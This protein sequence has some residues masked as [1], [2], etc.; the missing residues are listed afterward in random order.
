M[1]EYIKLFNGID[2][3]NGYEIND[4]PFT[5]TIKSASGESDI[6]LVCNKPY[7]SILIEGGKPRILTEVT[8]TGIWNPSA[9]DKNT[10]VII[11]GDVDLC[12]KTDCYSIGFEEGG[13]LTIN[14]DARLRVWEGGIVNNDAEI[15]T[16]GGYFTIVED[17][18]NNSWGEFLLHPSVITNC[19]PNA[20][21][22]ILA[23]SYTSSSTPSTD[24][25]YQRFGVP[26]YTAIKSITAKNP[27]TGNNVQLFVRRYENNRTWIT[28]GYIN[29]PGQSF[30]YDLMND[31]F[32]LYILQCNVP[33]EGTL[34]TLSGGLVGNIDSNEILYQNFQTGFSNSYLG[35]I[36]TKALL[37]VIKTIPN[38]IS[39]QILDTTAENTF[40]V[41]TEDNITIPKIFP[42][43]QAFV[44]EYTGSTNTSITFSYKNLVWDPS[45][46]EDTT[47]TRGLLKGNLM[48][49]RPA[50]IDATL[51]G[52]P[53]FDNPEPMFPL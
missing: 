22:E 47:P 41:Q 10:K 14:P 21:I 48:S 27:V 37:A 46:E 9:S 50:E 49:S 29:V 44:I 35:S 52:D 45:F 17:A 4:I 3:A 1:K 2:S 51:L 39:L 25:L 24:Y 33:E 23:K 19:H 12:G 26:T 43:G 30:R 28:V 31:Q 38:I 36:S 20:T 13:H 32:G 5:S 34:V 53:I 7:A 11:S 18:V 8:I 42:I 15:R 6:N 40:I 16:D